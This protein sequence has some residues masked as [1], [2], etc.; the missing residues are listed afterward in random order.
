VIND[1]TLAVT[2]TVLQSTQALIDECEARLTRLE[3]HLQ[4]PSESKAPSAKAETKNLN[5]NTND[6]A[7]ERKVV[8]DE[9][10]RTNKTK[11]KNRA[12]NQA[13]LKLLMDTYPQTFNKDEVKPL[14]I[15]IQDDLLADEK[16]AKNKIK[17]ALASYVRSP[18][19]FRAMVEGADR[20]DLAGEAAG[21]VT[22]EEAEHAK[23]QLKAFHQRRKEQ[24]KEQEK[25][26]KVQEREERI[27]N[28][29][30]QLVSMNKR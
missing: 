24:Q 5:V 14:K 8:N 6:R 21:K 23:Q 16:V 2:E 27:S 30:E 9:A 18:N 15:G 7:I 17:R 4:T 19:Y 10:T 20:V 11:T 26:R 3:N 29:L 22:A 13:A 12:A 25:Q 28:K 1:D